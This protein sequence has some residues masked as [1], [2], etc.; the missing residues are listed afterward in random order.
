MGGR[1]SERSRKEKGREGK[2]RGREGPVNCVKPWVRKV[3]SLSL[4]LAHQRAD[5]PSPTGGTD[6][7]HLLVAI[8][9]VFKSTTKISL[10]HFT[11]TMNE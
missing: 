9:V 1:G 5:T 3:A 7:P 4:I 8:S 10:L 2:D 6:I 11:A